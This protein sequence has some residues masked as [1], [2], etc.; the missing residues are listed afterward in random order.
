M[1][2]HFSSFEER[3]PRLSVVVPVRPNSPE[4]AT[5]LAALSASDLPRAEW[6]LVVVTSAE[7]ESAWLIGAQHADTVVR[8]PHGHWGAAYARNRGVEV[9]R[10]SYLLFVSADVCVEKD[11]V[12]GFIE[13]L[14]SEPAVGAVCGTYVDGGHQAHSH[15][16]AYQTLLHQFRSEFGAGATDTFTTGF[17]AIRRELFL[18]AGMFD[19]WRVEV[20][21][22]EGAEFGRR[23]LSL[24]SA[25]IVRPDLRASHLKD[26]TLWRTFGQSLRDPGIPWQDEL[27]LPTDAIINPGLLAVRR[28]E[29]AGMLLVWAALAAGTLGVLARD[30]RSSA[31]MYVLLALAALS[32][33]PLGSFIA[34]RRS[35]GFALLVFPIHMGK[36]ILTGLGIGHNWLVRHILGEPRPAPAVEAFAEVGLTTWPPV[37]QR[38]P[39]QSVTRSN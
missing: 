33:V 7:D 1:S 30:R 11:A 35:I 2:I 3:A 16:A 9:S 18:N 31:V 10:G 21:Q 29:V 37:P 22:I 6:E 27:C 39:A 5:S 13:V 17:G 26:W 34:R 4:L 14:D 32:W 25:V 8:L 36:L 23:L 24:G 28:V 20:P 38:R 15:V 19:E 12:S